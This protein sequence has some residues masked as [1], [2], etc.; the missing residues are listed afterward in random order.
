MRVLVPA[1]CR[2]RIFPSIACCQNQAPQSQT[3]NQGPPTSVC[4]VW[5][6]SGLPCGVKVI[7]HCDGIDVCRATEA[8]KLSSLKAVRGVSNSPPERSQGVRAR[9]QL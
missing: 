9:C 7:I 8:L 3:K 2:R 4:N 5:G 6:F 1:D